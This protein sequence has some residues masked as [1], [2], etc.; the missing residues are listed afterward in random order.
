M[1]NIALEKDKSVNN[2]VIINAFNVE[3]SPAVMA[4]AVDET[5]LK[6][7]KGKGLAIFPSVRPGNA[8][9]KELAYLST[10]AN[11]AEVKDGFIKAKNYGSAGII[12][13]SK[14]NPEKYAFINV[15]VVN[16][17]SSNSG[18]GS[19]TA[20]D[21]TAPIDLNKDPMSLI[22]KYQIL[23]YSINGD[24][25][26][27]ADSASSLR[28]NVNLDG[29]G[30]GIVKIL[31]YINLNGRE[32]RLIQKKNISNYGSIP[33]IFT[34]LGA[35]ITGDYTMEFTLDPVNYTELAR[36]GIVNKGDTLVLNIGKIQAFAPAGG[37]E[38]I[39]F[40]MKNLCLLKVKIQMTAIQKHLKHQ[41]IIIN[42]MKYR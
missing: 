17:E 12:I 40:L 4:V 19:F 39:L 24:K 42:Q 29:L 22:A 9:N 2:Q 21:G 6:I 32:A 10:N 11:V 26:K 37:W 28:V 33:D 41:K 13:Y 35:K 1:I 31:M 5:Y 30:A 16:E 20:P 38:A 18:S 14:S 15:D 36:Q 3:N 23:D 8:V 34:S 7:K 27:T 25:A